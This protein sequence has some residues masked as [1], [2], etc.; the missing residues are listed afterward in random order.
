MLIATTTPIFSFMLICNVHMYFHGRNASPISM[1]AEYAKKTQHQLSESC[2]LS[3]AL[4]IVTYH[5]QEGYTVS[6]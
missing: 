5:K 4:Q 6:Q 2:L 1:A 3:T